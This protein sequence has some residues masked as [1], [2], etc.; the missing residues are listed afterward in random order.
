[1]NLTLSTPGLRDIWETIETGIAALAGNQSLTK[2]FRAPFCR[3]HTSS[4]CFQK[5]RAIFRLTCTLTHHPWLPE[6]FR[7]DSGR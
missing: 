1:L 5:I 4:S 2:F 3:L 7:M 6:A